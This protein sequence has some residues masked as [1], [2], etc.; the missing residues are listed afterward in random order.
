MDVASLLGVLA[1]FALIATNGFFVAAEF[2]LVKVR[3]TR[4]D[5]LVNEGKSSAR[6]VQQQ[7][8]HLD[9][10]IAA[11]Q[12]GITLASLAL[13][14]IGE[15]SLAHLLEPIFAW[16]GGPVEEFAHSITIIIAFLLITAGH[17]I[18]GELVPKA[19][20]LQRDEGTV[21]FT[22][23]PLHIFAYIFRPIII[24]MNS[25]GN[26]IVRMLG[27]SMASEHGAIHSP[28]ELEMLVIQ[29]RK[30]GVLQQQEEDLI[31]HV[32]DFE[33]TTARQV[34]VPRTE[35]VAVSVTN[36]LPELQALITAQRYTRYPVY[37]QSIDAIIGMVH[38]KDLV[39]YISPQAQAFDLRKIMRPILAVPE[40]MSIGALMTQMKRQRTHLAVV[41]DEYG[42]TAGIVTLEDIVEELVGE[43]QDEFD[44]LKEG[45]RR[46]IETLPDGSSSVD[47]LLA[48]SDFAERFGVKIPE[49]HVQTIG[50]Y[51]LER[52]DRIPAVG[53]TLRLGSY[54]L[55]VDEMDGRRVA[56]VRVEPAKHLSNQNGTTPENDVH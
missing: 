48:L 35:V 30:A 20:A 23:R 31:R 3:A 9:T 1:V 18:L 47:G 37:E 4:I 54:L 16:I 2:A 46:E 44:T 21:L 25:I 32:F 40:S 41:I 27:M 34:M 39:E 6:I 10:Y 24:F 43:V 52:E 38:L 36:D 15:P 22:A 11:T 12:L 13:G 53:D 50:G 42:T 28:E 49:S 51:I 55:R 7:V 17:I 56:R 45:V 14:W 33:E 29:S 26:S 19:I 5:Q 8:Q